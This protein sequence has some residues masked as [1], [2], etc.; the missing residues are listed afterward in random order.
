[1][2]AEARLGAGGMGYVQ[3][4]AD[5]AAFL[6]QRQ[7]PPQAFGCLRALC[8]RPLVRLIFR[9]DVDEWLLIS[10]VSH[11]RYVLLRIVT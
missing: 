7:P 11:C 3:G 10:T 4:M 9:L 8:G 1:M 5:V 2:T 6:L